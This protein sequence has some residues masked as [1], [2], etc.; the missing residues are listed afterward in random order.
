MSSAT[1]NTKENVPEELRRYLAIP[2]W[3]LILQVRL[4][5]QSDQDLKGLVKFIDSHT[6]D[7][8]F[9][10]NVIFEAN[11]EKGKI[12]LPSHGVLRL[13]VLN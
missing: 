8:L 6:D 2:Q 10:D 1:G 13:F 5:E 9:I 11:N 12:E 4:A 7:L 3:T